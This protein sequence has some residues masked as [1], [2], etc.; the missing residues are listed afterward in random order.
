MNWLPGLAAGIF[1]AA[2]VHA[3]ELDRIVAV[4]DEDVVMQS[5]LEEQMLRVR[6]QLRNQGTQ[7]PP[8]AILE[9]QVMERLVLEKI[10]LQLADRI[11]VEVEE[12]S[13]DHAIVDIARRNELSLEQFREIL[14][15]EGHQFDYFRE[16][17]RQE[18]V[19]AK[20]RKEEVDN[21]VKVREQEIENFLSNENN[22]EDNALEYR[23]SHILITT[24]VGADD[25]E[26]RALRNK[27]KDILDRLDAGEDFG[28]LAI[29]VSD[30]QTALDKGD[31]GWRKGEEIPTLFADSVSTMEIGEVS[32]IITSPSGLHIVKLA[33][34]RTGEK[35]MVEQHK[36]RHILIKPNELLPEDQVFG[37]ISQIR[38]R[39]DGGA[40]FAQLAQRNSDD[41]KSALEGGDLGWVS[42]G[43]MVP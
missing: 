35:I 23:L 33:D 3:T 37:R 31:L 29:A 5:E 32:G 28:A 11:G 17:I 15:S 42:K 30:G 13:L 24:P 38:L 16:Q 36:V 1:A 21:R 10:Q 7:T 34:Q 25:D 22:E 39:L 27:A 20:L 26:L 43:N 4:V 18:I 19:M 40:D 41:R 8:T 14:E 12:D 2:A 6:L 9:R